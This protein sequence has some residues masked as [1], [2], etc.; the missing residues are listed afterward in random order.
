M[1]VFKFFGQ[2]IKKK[3]KDCL[4]FIREGGAIPSPDCFLID[5]NSIFYGVVRQLYI[6]RPL[7]TFEESYKVICEA[8]SQLISQVNPNTTV[9]I[10]ID[11]VAGLCKQSQQRKRRFKAASEALLE[12]EK[13]LE[14]EEETL[15][16]ISGFDTIHFTAGTPYMVGLCKYIRTYFSKSS[17]PYTFIFDDMFNP[18]EGEHKILEYIRG[19]KEHR[20]FMIYSPDADLIMLSLAARRPNMF[21]IRPN[22]P[23]ETRKHDLQVDYYIIHIDRLAA[24]ISTKYQWESNNQVVQPFIKDQFIVDVVLFLFILGNDFLPGFPYVKIQDDGIEKLFEVYRSVVPYNGFLVHPTSRQLNQKSISK[25]MQMMAQKEPSLLLQ[26]YVDI[27]DDRRYYP[28]EVLNKS[29]SRKLSGGYEIDM[30]KYRTLYYTSK[31][32]FTSREEINILCQEYFRGLCF[33]IQYYTRRIPTYDWYYPYSYSPVFYDLYTYSSK[34]DIEANFTFRPPLALTEALFS[35]IPPS[36]YFVLPNESLQAKMNILSRTNPK[37]SERVETDMSGLRRKGDDSHEAVVLL[38]MVDYDT[39]KGLLKEFHLHDPDP[40]MF[41]ISRRTPVS[42]AGTFSSYTIQ[43]DVQVYPRPGEGAL[44]AILSQGRPRYE[45]AKVLEY[46]KYVQFAEDAMEVAI[47]GLNEVLLWWIRNKDIPK[48]RGSTLFL[49]SN[50]ANE[51]ETKTQ[52]LTTKDVQRYKYLIHYIQT[53]LG[54]R[55][56]YEVSRSIEAS[57]IM[58]DTFVSRENRLKSFA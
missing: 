58:E 3:Y 42:P 31:F 48:K 50:A 57:E 5:A 43:F 4:L 38:P 23:K 40:G 29:V 12:Q 54:Y 19:D 9:Y 14:G 22:D 17:H 21:V 7:S 28:D 6:D 47:V 30:T 25:M 8:M 56:R 10:S 46:G 55:V 49:M 20:S 18:G 24:K 27:S 32:H 11:G 2:W 15:H 16:P 26:R 52:N 37:F 36:K 13:K 35:V 41:I 53:E 45:G 1:G 51:L 39:I 34:Y 44:G 33:V